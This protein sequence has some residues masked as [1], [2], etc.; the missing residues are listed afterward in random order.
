MK[1][2]QFIECNMK[3][4]FHEK[5]FLKCDAEISPRTFSEKVEHISNEPKILCS[6]FLFYAKLRAIETY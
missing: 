1:F 5:S 6:L 3:I 4:I 2:G